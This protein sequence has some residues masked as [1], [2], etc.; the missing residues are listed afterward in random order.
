MQRAV[1][2]TYPQYAA[3]PAAPKHYPTAHSTSSA[4]SASANPN[5]DWTKISDLAERRR[6]QNRIAQRNYRKSRRSAIDHCLLLRELTLH[7]GKKLKKRLEDLEARARSS[8][9]SPEQSHEELAEPESAPEHAASISNQ[10]QRSGSNH[11]RSDRTP[12][13]VHQQY[14]LPS[15]DRGMFSQ[16][17]TRQM[18]TSPPPFSYGGFH[19]A[20]LASYS[21]Y[22]PAQSF[23]TM[24]GTSDMQ[25]YPPYVPPTQ[26]SYQHIIPS[27]TTPPIKQEYYQDD[28]MSP[29]SM[30]Y[31]TMAG[32]DVS[33]AQSYQDISA[34]V[35]TKPHYPPY[36]RSYSAPSWPTNSG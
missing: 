22:P 24:P 18:S 20:E 29:F 15:E 4:F 27:M 33:A 7:S 31:A 28:E 12:E 35:S 30:S 16:Q 13:T 2:Y 21:T 10:Q 9:G 1:S 36:S 8:S 34:Y 32:V 23:C 14:V 19:S 17:Y 25:Y 3:S 6:I 11:S 5:E 26:Q